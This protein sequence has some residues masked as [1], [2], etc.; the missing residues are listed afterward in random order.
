VASLQNTD[1]DG[2]RTLVP[3]ARHRRRGML[4]VAVALFQ[5]WVWGTRIGNLLGDADDFSTAFV[6]VHLVLYVTSIAVG[7][8]LA[9][10]GVRM[11][12]EARREA[13]DP[14]SPR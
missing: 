13:D 14:G 2:E 12:R 7:I 3:T 4:L 11:W 6:A 10:L 1:R 8:V 9:V 5:F